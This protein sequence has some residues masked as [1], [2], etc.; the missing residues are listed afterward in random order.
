MTKGKDVLPALTRFEKAIPE[1]ASLRQVRLENGKVRFGLGYN[2]EET[3][4]VLWTGKGKAWA[5]P[6]SPAETTKPGQK[7]KIFNGK[8]YFRDKRYDMNL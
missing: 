3:L 5:R 6:V 2:L 7:M 8:V 4:F 1:T